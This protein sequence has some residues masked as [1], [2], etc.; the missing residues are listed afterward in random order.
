MQVATKQDIHVLPLG[1]E[2]GGLLFNSQPLLEDLSSDC[3]NM[4]QDLAVRDVPGG[5]MI[6]DSFYPVFEAPEMPV[7]FENEL[8]DIHISYT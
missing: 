8:I 6:G 2:I 1:I 3:I 7:S 4:A 5:V